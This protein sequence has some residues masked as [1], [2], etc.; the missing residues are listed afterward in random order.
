MMETRKRWPKRGGFLAYKKQKGN[1]I[2]H[3]RLA[4]IG[5]P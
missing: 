5:N 1:H 4:A 3:D 2:S